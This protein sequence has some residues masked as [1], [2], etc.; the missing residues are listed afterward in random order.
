MTGFAAEEAK[1][2]KLIDRQLGLL[3]LLGVER[4][5]SQERRLTTASWV[6][7]ITNLLARSRRDAR[8]GTPVGD[9]P[10][11]ERGRCIEVPWQASLGLDESDQ[12]GIYLR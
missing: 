10:F 12:R 8:W 7:V 5:F 11:R 2:K 9:F 3:A 1:L 6:A 4:E